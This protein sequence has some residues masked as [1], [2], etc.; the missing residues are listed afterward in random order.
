MIHYTTGNVLDAEADALVNTVNTVGVMGKGIALMFKEAFPENYRVY[1]EACK[2]GEVQAGRVH[3][4]EN[5]DLMGPRWI[6]N[7]PTKKHWRGKTR[8]EWIDAG[9]EDL[10]RVIREHNIRSIALPPLGAGNGGLDWESVK[11]RIEAAL[12]ELEDVDIQV[13]EP[14]RE[15]QNVMKRSGVEK[16]TPARALI[17]E[18]VRQYWVLG[19]P[20]SVL[21]VQKLAWFLER[22]IDERSLDNPLDLRFQA[23]RYGPYADRL[24]KLLNDLDGSYLHCEKRLADAGPTD[25]IWFDETCK[26]R[27]DAYLL[28]GEARPYHEALEQVSRI[29]DG[30][31]SP[32]GMELLASVDWLLEREGCEASLEG[33]KEGLRH[34]PG[35]REAA[36]R[37][38]RLF[39][40]NMLQVAIDRLTQSSTKTAASQ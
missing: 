30:F 6:I 12:D 22:A 38:L 13:F 32:L 36:E 9:L 24:Q 26:D 21:E 28:S 17:T 29:I 8:L 18:A 23:N 19:I 11:P 2:A 31:Q 37:K 34:W 15:Y 33:I 4:T 16:L 3:V 1:A 14:S 40:D 25:T 20:C 27:V 5:Q 35:G 7:F 10:K 39:N